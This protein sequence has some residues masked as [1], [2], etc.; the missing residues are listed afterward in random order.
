MT[1]FQSQGG[2]RQTAPRS[3]GHFAGFKRPAAREDHQ[4]CGILKTAKAVKAS[5]AAAPAF[6]SNSGRRIEQMH[7]RSLRNAYA[8]PRQCSTGYLL[9]VDPLDA[10]PG[11]YPLQT[12]IKHTNNSF[13]GSWSFSGQC[14]SA[15]DWKFRLLPWSGVLFSADDQL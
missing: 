2:M 13:C 9:D 11:F 6:L 15:F 8:P 3:I 4:A 7:N 5:F 14:L 10:G 12:L 1:L